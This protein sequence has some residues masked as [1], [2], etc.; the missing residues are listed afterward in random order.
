M[1]E[2]E[3]VISE[4][5]S[6]YDIYMLSPKLQYILGLFIKKLENFNDIEIIKGAI[7][8]F[9][10]EIMP[11]FYLSKDQKEL[12]ENFDKKYIEFRIDNKKEMSKFLNINE[13]QDKIEY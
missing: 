8:L 9:K 12:L 7:S 10:I 11:L 3:K 1:F 6:S 13:V 5:I 2:K 4:F